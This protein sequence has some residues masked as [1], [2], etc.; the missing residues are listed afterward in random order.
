MERKNIAG[1]PSEYC[2][3]DVVSVV[4]LFYFFIWGNVSFVFSVSC[5]AVT[6]KVLPRGQNCTRTRPRTRWVMMR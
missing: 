5:E 1:E 6:V 2:N 4:F 3:D